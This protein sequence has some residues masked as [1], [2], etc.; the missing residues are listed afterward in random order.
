MHDDDRLGRRR[1]RRRR[2]RQESVTRILFC[3]LI[4]TTPPPPFFSRPETT[5]CEH[6]IHRRNDRA[7]LPERRAPSHNPALSAAP[8]STRAFCSPQAAPSIHMMHAPPPPRSVRCP[9]V[10]ASHTPYRG[11]V[12]RVWGGPREWDTWGGRVWLWLAGD[13][14]R[15]FEAGRRQLARFPRVPFLSFFSFSLL[16]LREHTCT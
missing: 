8:I 16:A 10:R 11:Q 15:V 3:A 5:S 14:S 9:S 7:P 13:V 1:R 12:A 6:G 4:S 2:R